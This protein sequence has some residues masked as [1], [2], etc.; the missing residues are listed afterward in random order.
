[1][2]PT[3]KL[4][5]GIGATL[6]KSCSKI[7]N[8]GFT[9]ELLCTDCQEQALKLLKRVDTILALDSSNFT[10]GELIDQM[11]ELNINEFIRHLY[12]EGS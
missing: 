9:S 1:M 10:D 4:N 8:T 3:H 7:I 2:K 6:C 11:F 5:G 12:D